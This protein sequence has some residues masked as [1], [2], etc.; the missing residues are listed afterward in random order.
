MW[1][2]HVV[3]QKLEGEV[4]VIRQSVPGQAREQLSTRRTE[5]AQAN[6]F[7]CNSEQNPLKV[8]CQDRELNASGALTRLCPRLA[9]RMQAHAAGSE[10]ERRSREDGGLLLEELTVHTPSG[11]RLLCSVPPQPLPALQTP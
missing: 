5:C 3:T 7:T 2:S 10:I 8:L 4:G 6:I 11:E 9:V 1:R